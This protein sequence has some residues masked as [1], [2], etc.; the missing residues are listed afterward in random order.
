MTSDNKYIPIQIQPQR[1]GQSTVY[2]DTS[3]PSTANIPCEL[4]NLTKVE[5]IIFK[6]KV[7]QT[8]DG[9]TLFS[10]HHKTEPSGSSLNL[11]LRD[12]YKKDTVWLHLISDDAGHDPYL[13]IV[14][15]PMHGL[16]SVKI[17]PVSGNLKICIQTTK[18][19]STLIA[20][21]PM[22]LQTQRNTSIEI[23]SMNGSH[24]VAKIMSEKEGGSAW[25]VFRFSVDMESCE[26]IVILGAF[27][28]LNFH[29]HE[30][31][32][33]E[34]SS[35]RFQDV[36]IIDCM[37]WENGSGLSSRLCE[38]QRDGVLDSAEEGGCCRDCH[39]GCKNCLS[40]F[41][42]CLQCCTECCYPCLCLLTVIHCCL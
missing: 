4:E 24:Q 7:F 32:K 13:Q 25:V 20:S 22:F 40:C 26:K 23:L 36:W 12:C 14:A 31:R 27:L 10:V 16:G 5:E 42:N 41:H 19:T 37:D 1:Q 33:L 15:L 39:T 17:D 30:V 9:K 6:D 29:L 28:Y 35:T 38:K 2:Q 3:T 21:L 34:N 11:Y 8:R 18:D